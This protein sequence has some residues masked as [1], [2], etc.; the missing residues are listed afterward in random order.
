MKLEYFR[1]GY[2]YKYE[3]TVKTANKLN[4]FSL[5]KFIVIYQPQVALLSLSKENGI[6]SA[7]G[8]MLFVIGQAGPIPWPPRSPDLTP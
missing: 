3:T 4:K 1:N 8:T 6:C 7:K 2:R 5:T